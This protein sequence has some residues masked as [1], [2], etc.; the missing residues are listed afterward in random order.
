M[1]DTADATTTTDVLD[2]YELSDGG[3][4]FYHPVTDD[5]IDE[6]YLPWGQVAAGSS[7]DTRLR[8]RNE[9]DGY[10]A[11]AVYVAVAD[12][13]EAGAVSAAGQHF[14]SLDGQTFARQVSVGD[15]PPNS[16]GGPVWLRRV[17]PPQTPGGES[18][19]LLTA[20]A[21]A[22]TPAVADADATTAAAVPAGDVYDPAAHPGDPVADEQAEL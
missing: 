2:G 17:T 14:V 11:E 12:P 21:S 5:E 13:G 7:A 22:W 8:V 1:T 4:I 3:L 19:F 18:S 16:T 6:S 20:T 10:I 15:L 9:S